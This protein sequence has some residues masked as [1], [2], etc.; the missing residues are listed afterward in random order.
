[1]KLAQEPCREALRVARALIASNEGGRVRKRSNI[2]IEM[3]DIEQEPGTQ[4][5]P[6]KRMDKK[7]KDKKNRKMGTKN[8]N[9][10]S[11]HNGYS[12]RLQYLV[13][14]KSFVSPLQ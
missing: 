8:T 4:R 3:Q 10:T 13:A 7:G 1:M 14:D 2:N 6:D 12:Q 11:E 5:K 9:N